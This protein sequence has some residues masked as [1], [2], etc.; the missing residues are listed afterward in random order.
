MKLE[1]YRDRLLVLGFIIFYNGADKSLARPYW[2][3]Q[4][5]VRHF[6]SDAQVIATVETWLEGQHC[7]FFFF[8]LEK[9]RVWSL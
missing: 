6:L 8:F 9:V 4:L 5:E 3:K 7:E 1:V 2:E